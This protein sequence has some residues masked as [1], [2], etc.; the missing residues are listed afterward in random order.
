MKFRL[1]IK[2]TGNTINL[3]LIDNKK[4]VVAESKWVDNKDLSEKILTK[5][6]LLLKRKKVSL[7]DISKFD[8]T[9]SGK[10]GF[11]AEQVGEITV[12]VLNFVRA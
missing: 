11:T 8:F 4:K 2:I 1:K 7:S 10:C 6:D 12:K 3:F 5:I 9:S